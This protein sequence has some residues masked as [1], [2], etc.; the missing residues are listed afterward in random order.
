MA[1]QK[2]KDIITGIQFYVDKIVSDPALSGE[3]FLLHFWQSPSFL[4]V[5]K[6]CNR[7]ESSFA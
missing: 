7:N 1:A 5:D 4:K 2:Q 6:Y 3:F